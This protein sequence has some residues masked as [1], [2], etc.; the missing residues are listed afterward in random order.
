MR[1]VQLRGSKASTSR[2]SSASGS[3]RTAGRSWG[4][5]IAAIIKRGPL[6]V[7][8]VADY[9]I[10]ALDALSQAHAA[11]IVHRDLKPANLFLA[12]RHDGSLHVKVLDFGIS[13]NLSPMD[14][15]GITSTK[16]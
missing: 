8:D 14:G 2:G 15:Q 10:E 9:A 16:A 6:R 1:R 11:G 7:H 3:C 13:K 4:P 5:D 12:R